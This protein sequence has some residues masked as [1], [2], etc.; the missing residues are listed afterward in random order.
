MTFIKWVATKQK[1]WKLVEGQALN[2]VFIFFSWFNLTNLNKSN[3]SKSLKSLCINWLQNWSHSSRRT[4]ASMCNAC[5]Y[6]NCMFHLQTHSQNWFLALQWNICNL[7]VQCAFD[8]LQ[9]CVSMNLV[10]WIQIKT[11][12]EDDLPQVMEGFMNFVVTTIALSL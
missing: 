6:S 1:I 10:F 2:L 8:F 3:F 11:P 4:Q 9:V 7:K 12:K 5:E